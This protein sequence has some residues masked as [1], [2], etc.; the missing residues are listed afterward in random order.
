VKKFWNIFA[1]V[2]AMAAL[3]LKTVGAFANP[4]FNG[5]SA[6]QRA[7]LKSLGMKVV[8]PNYV[9][10]FQVAG[11]L[12]SCPL[13]Q[14]KTGMCRFGPSY[15]IIYRSSKNICFVIEGASGGLGDVWGEYK[16]PVFSKLLRRTT[17]YFN[18]RPGNLAS[19]LTP[20]PTLLQVPQDLVTEWIPLS[21]DS[22]GRLFEGNYRFYSGKD[23]SRRYT[24]ESPSTYSDYAGFGKD[25]VT[26]INACVT[27][28]TPRQAISIVESLKL[29]P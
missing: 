5:L 17:L 23:L 14:P 13:N 12:T 6:A 24:K 11:V 27:S 7:R 29:L 26:N 19:N 9:P 25:T 16:V 18:T 3:S 21:S 4:Q 15:A 10:G 20:P 2:A 28:L 1:A 8:I 22:Q